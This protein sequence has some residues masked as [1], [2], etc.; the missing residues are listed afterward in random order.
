MDS[1][2]VLNEIE[3]LNMIRDIKIQ[4]HKLKKEF[5]DFKKTHDLPSN[6][7]ETDDQS[8]ESFDQS[9]IRYMSRDDFQY[10][11]ERIDKL[12]L[13]LAAI[14]NKIDKIFCYLEVVEVQKLKNMKDLADMQ[15][16]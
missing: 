15:E 14:V 6:Q 8:E 4:T 7:T 10:A 9:D 5:K 2:L 3:K 16:V 1:D 12:E 11:F 13:K